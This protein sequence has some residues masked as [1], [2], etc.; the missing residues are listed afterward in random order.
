MK[1]IILSTKQCVCNKCKTFRKLILRHI[2]CSIQKCTS[3]HQVVIIREKLVQMNTS[4]EQLNLNNLPA[5]YKLGKNVWKTANE[6]KYQ[7][8]YER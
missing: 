2:S 6:M 8:F 7:E 3:S 4:T 5:I 1:V